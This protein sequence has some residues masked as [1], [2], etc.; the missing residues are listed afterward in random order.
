MSSGNVSNITSCSFS[1]ITFSSTVSTHIVIRDFIHFPAA[2]K[3]SVTEILGLVSQHIYLLCYEF[4]K[5]KSDLRFPQRWI[6]IL[7]SSQTRHRV[8]WSVVTNVWD[9]HTTSPLTPNNGLVGFYETLTK[10][11]PTTWC[12]IPKLSH[13]SRC[14]YG[15]QV[16]GKR[17]NAVR[18]V[19]KFDIGSPHYNLAGSSTTPISNKFKL[20]SK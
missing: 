9:Q 2:S 19:L 15:W 4:P 12:H 14:S 5:S 11:Y 10:G 7:L 8:V 18:Q 1:Q 13:S 20:I 6:W 16:E 3:M 17:D